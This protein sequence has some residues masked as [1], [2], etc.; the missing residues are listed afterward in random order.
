MLDHQS[1]HCALAADGACV[2]AA[3]CCSACGLCGQQTTCRA[4][5][6]GLR[7]TAHAAG[8]LRLQGACRVDDLKTFVLPSRL[9][10][11]GKIFLVWRPDLNGSGRPICLAAH[12]WHACAQPNH[13]VRHAHSL[14][15]TRPP[16]LPRVCTHL[17]EHDPG[18]NDDLKLS[19]FRAGCRLWGNFYGLE[20]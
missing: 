5:H 17:H 19:F 15:S 4:S 18:L 11:V 13:S 6:A 16:N 9:S 12:K 14:P 7:S 1:A 10:S 3:E 8:N 2:G 20:T